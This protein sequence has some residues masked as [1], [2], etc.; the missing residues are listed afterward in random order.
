M[1]GNGR[2]GNDTG[3]VQKQEVDGCTGENGLQ[4]TKDATVFDNLPRR[5]PSTG[6]LGPMVYKMVMAPKRTPMGVSFD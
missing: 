3:Q 4:D 6:A 2:T 5:M 1:R